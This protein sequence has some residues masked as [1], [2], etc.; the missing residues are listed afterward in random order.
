MK[1][2]PLS[3]QK[4]AGILS[5]SITMVIVV[6]LILLNVIMAVLTEKYPL[7]LDLTSNKVFQLSQ[8]SIDYLAGLEKPVHITIMNT[9]ESF[10]RGG[11]YFAQAVSVI[12]QYT[13]YNPNITL[14]YEDLMANPAY[15]QNNS[16]LELSIDDILIQSGEKTEKLTAYDIFNVEASYYGGRIT[17]S[18]AEQAMTVAIMNVTEESKIKI[19]FL[20]GHGES[21]QEGL[22]ALLQKNGFETVKASLLTEGVPED[23]AIAVLSAPRRDITEEEAAA[24]DHFLENGGA[25][26][27]YVYCFGSLEQGELPHL[28]KWLA[29][30]GLAFGEGAVAETNRRNTITDNIFFGTASFDDTVLTGKMASEEIPITVPYSRPIQFLFTDNLGYTTKTLLSYSED[31]GIIDE[32]TQGLGDMV[33][34]GPI[35][36]AGMSTLQKDGMISGVLLFGSSMMAASGLFSSGSFS[37]ADYFL[38][39]FNILAERENAFSVAPK[40]LGGGFLAIN[41]IQI[42]LWGI[43]LALLLP[44]SVRFTGLYF[45]MRRRKR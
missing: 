19:A 21:G 4:K 3:I 13:K 26:G 35:P 34:Q 25:Y 5:V 33:Q 18:K 36:V 14:E 45:W 41:P 15:L 12:E 29:K 7:K 17:S 6:C 32:Q 20:E 28:E 23:A 1:K 40:T 10:L 24:L 37:N 39:S 16:E 38:S 42:L 43:F 11:D 27:K 31:A 22:E 9:R 44:L 8:D 30:W 2:K